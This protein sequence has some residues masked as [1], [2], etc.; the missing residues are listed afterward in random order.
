MNILPQ[1][2]MHLT[3]HTGYD[4]KWVDIG[5]IS[6]WTID[7]SPEVNAR[8]KTLGLDLSKAVNS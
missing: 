7:Y 4:S 5:T 3:Q 6:Q 1:I 8:A 2:D